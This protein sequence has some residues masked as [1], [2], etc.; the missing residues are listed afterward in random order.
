MKTANLILG[1]LLIG[2]LVACATPKTLVLSSPAVSM[3]NGYFE[4]GM[5]FAEAGPVNAQFCTGE[6]SQTSK[7]DLNV[8]FMDELIYRAQQS[9]G[10]KYIANAQFFAQG[11]CMLLE[12]TAMK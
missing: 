4:P 3:T 2:S 10:A 7:G 12:G 11:N 1:A 6:D 5:K 9:S 8:G